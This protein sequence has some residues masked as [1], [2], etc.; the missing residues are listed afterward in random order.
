MPDIDYLREFCT[1]YPKAR[2]GFVVYRMT[3]EDDAQWVRFMEHL[4]YVSYAGAPTCAI[5]YR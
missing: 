5:L 4:K 2:L 3:Y 1:Q